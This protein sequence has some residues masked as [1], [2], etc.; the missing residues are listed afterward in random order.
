MILADGEKSRQLISSLDDVLKSIPNHLTVSQS[1]N[2][3]TEQANKYHTQSN[4]Q[5]KIFFK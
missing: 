4:N 3:D 5:C 2:N 1:L